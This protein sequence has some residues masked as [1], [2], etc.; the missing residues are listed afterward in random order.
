MKVKVNEE[1]CIGCGACVSLCPEV[2]DFN[3]E[4]YATA[5]EEKISEELT[6]KVIDALESCPV[7]AIKRND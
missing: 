1:E 5:K 4:G 3:D 6:Q 2:F 7:D